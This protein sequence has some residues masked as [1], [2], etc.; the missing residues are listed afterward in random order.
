MLIVP[1]VAMA[2]GFR[3]EP[4]GAEIPAAADTPWD[5]DTVREVLLRTAERAPVAVW[6]VLEEDD[7]RARLSDQSGST[8]RRLFG[9]AVPTPPRTADVETLADRAANDD[10]SASDALITLLE[11][12]DSPKRIVHPM[13]ERFARLSD[14]PAAVIDVLDR[15]SKAVPETVANWQETIRGWNGAVRVGEERGNKLYC[16]HVRIGRVTDND[17][18]AEVASLLEEF[19]TCRQLL[20]SNVVPPL[21]QIRPNIALP[22]LLGH[23][24]DAETPPRFV[25][26]ILRSLATVD[27]SAVDGW[28]PAVRECL[29]Q[30]LSH[31]EHDIRMYAV[32]ALNEFPNVDEAVLADRLKSETETR[33]RFEIVK[34]MNDPP[35]LSSK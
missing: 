10:A 14:P 16:V 5:E 34:A 28:H 13:M 20:R 19:R 2:A 25:R 7:L 27:W 31:D 11:R 4:S 1:R 22:T 32:Q 35:S 3:T 17:D 30:L 18:L 6:D 26:L 24:T 21:V 12:D 15:A 23:L 33:V 29:T 9:H 8:A